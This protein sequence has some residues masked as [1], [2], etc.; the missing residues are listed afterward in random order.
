MFFSCSQ[1]KHKLQTGLSNEYNQGQYLLELFSTAAVKQDKVI[2][3][4]RT[5]DDLL[6]LQ[7]TLQHIGYEQP[8]FVS[9]CNFRSLQS[10]IP[11]YT[12]S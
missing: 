11:P 10:Y 9:I 6:F 8:L 5:I 7:M 12:S 2:Y 4:Q 3:I 1:I